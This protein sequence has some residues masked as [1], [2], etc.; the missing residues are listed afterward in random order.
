MAPERIQMVLFSHV[1]DQQ[2]QKEEDDYQNRQ[3]GV[4][5]IIENEKEIPTGEHHDISTPPALD[6]PRARRVDDENM[7]RIQ[8]LAEELQKLRAHSATTAEVKAQLREEAL[9]SRQ[10]AARH[11]TTLEELLKQAAQQPAL[12]AAGESA[13]AAAEAG[14]ES[15]DVLCHV[16]W[17]CG[18]KG[19]TDKQIPVV[20][21]PLLDQ[22]MMEVDSGAQALN[23]KERQRLQQLEAADRQRKQAREQALLSKGKNCK[24][25]KKGAGKGRVKKRGGRKGGFMR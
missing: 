17:T 5:K 22:Q 2:E 13:R 3:K 9:R 11:T 19:I 14:R 16:L 1:W 10:I 8:A 4:H 25:D 21:D 6:D 23:S 7:A 15:R 12:K 24:G 20:G 18:A